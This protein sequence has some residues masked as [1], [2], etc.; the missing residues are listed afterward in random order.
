MVSNALQQCW[1]SPREC[2]IIVTIGKLGC[3]SVGSL[4]PLEPTVLGSG[5][6]TGSLDWSHRLDAHVRDFRCFCRGDLVVVRMTQHG[7]W[8]CRLKDKARSVSVLAVTGCT[9]EANF[10]KVRS[11]ETVLPSRC[12]RQPSWLIGSPQSPV[13]RSPEAR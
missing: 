5:R 8:V 3:I 1:S 4:R 13:A 7:Q 12:A 6:V 11:E 2:S 10:S 9:S